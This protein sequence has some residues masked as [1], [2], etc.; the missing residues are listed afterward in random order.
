M[1]F[2]EVDILYRPHL[3]FLN[4][5]NLLYLNLKVNFNMSFLNMNF[6]WEYYQYNLK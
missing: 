1:A 6:K 3:N 2:F 5:A 4:F